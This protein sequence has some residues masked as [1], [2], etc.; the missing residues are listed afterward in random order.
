MMNKIYFRHTKAFVRFIKLDLCGT[1]IILGFCEHV[2]S[3]GSSCL[4]SVVVCS[5]SHSWSS[6]ERFSCHSHTD[7]STP[8]LVPISNP[9]IVKNFFDMNQHMY[10][11]SLPA[12]VV[13]RNHLAH[14]EWFEYFFSDLVASV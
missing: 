12:S 4:A 9:V 5:I 1:I 8:V 7:P 6:C 11:N 2:V 3:I 13:I 14:Y 10:S